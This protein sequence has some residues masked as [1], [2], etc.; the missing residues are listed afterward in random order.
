[1]DKYSDMSTL[2]A[3]ICA[4]RN[5]KTADAVK[6]FEATLAKNPN[7]RDALYNGAAL[8]YEL[9][10]GQDMLPLVHRLVAIDPNNPDNISLSAYA[11]NV[12]NEQWKPPGVTPAPAPTPAPA[13]PTK[14]GAKP[15]AKVATVTPPPAP[16]SPFVDSVA[17][18]MK[19]SDDM[20]QKLVVVEFVRYADR[21]MLKG[22][23]DNRTKAAKSYEI[24]FEFLD[25]TG[26]VVDK[27]VVKVENVVPGTP[28]TFTINSA[29]PKIAAWR[30]API[31]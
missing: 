18:Y 26:A 12:L 22:E 4:N 2:Q 6:M 21:A 31:K 13:A 27:Q 14:P 25:L 29:K 19:L 15:A 5:G 16:P 30:Y 23:V 17:K 8:L 1:V 28:G 9:R 24:E 11:Y 10:R 3:A 20:P 7:S